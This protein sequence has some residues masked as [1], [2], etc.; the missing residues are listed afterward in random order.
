MPPVFIVSKI[1]TN[2]G[3]RVSSSVSLKKCR[4]FHASQPALKAED[5]CRVSFIDVGG[6]LTSL[7]IL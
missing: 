3:D 6:E 7:L 5:T 2:P 4:T 1:K